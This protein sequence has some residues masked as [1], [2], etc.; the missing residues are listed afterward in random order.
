MW[1][2]G[3]ETGMAAAEQGDDAQENLQDILQG[4][5]PVE[6]LSGTCTGKEEPLPEKNGSGPDRDTE[7]NKKR[8]FSQ[9]DFEQVM[10]EECERERR[11]PAKEMPKGKKL[12]S[13]AKPPE[14]F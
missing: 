12:Y 5:A 10:R 6:E 11:P 8:P 3:T 9:T 7:K 2:T 13:S 4:T 1:P 14:D